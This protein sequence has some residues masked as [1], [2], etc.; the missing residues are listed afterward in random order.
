V[1]VL[2]IVYVFLS[3]WVCV[4][5]LVRE[6]DC[7]C[8]CVCISARDSLSECLCKLVY[9]VCVCLQGMGV[10]ICLCIIRIFV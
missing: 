6:R 1:C 2:H 3:D 8:V 9:D 4:C 10:R 5:I 7:L